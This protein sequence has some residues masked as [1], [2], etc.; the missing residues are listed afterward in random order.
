M[1]EQIATELRTFMDQTNDKFEKTNQL[2]Q[3]A[4]QSMNSNNHERPIPNSRRDS[5]SNHSE[6]EHSTESSALRPTMP[7][8]LTRE[9]PIMEEKP[10]TSSVEELAQMYA[11]LDLEVQRLISFKEYYEVRNQVNPN[12]RKRH[13]DKDLKARIRKMSLPYFDG[14]EKSTAQSWVQKLDTYLSLSPMIE[15]NAI[16]FATLFLA[17]IAQDWW[18]LSLITQGHQNITTYG[19][20]SQ[21]LSKRFNQRHLEWYFRELTLLTQQGSVEDYANEFQNFAVVVPDLSQG[22]LT[23]LFVEGHKESINKIVNPLERQRLGEA[24]QRAIKVE[25]KYSKEKPKY[26]SKAYPKNPRER[27]DVSVHLDTVPE[28]FH[29]HPSSPLALSDNAVANSQGFLQEMDASAGQFCEGER[30]LEKHKS[31]SSEVPMHRTLEVALQDKG[32]ER[33][34]QEANASGVHFC[35]GDESLPTQKSPSS[36]VPNTQFVSTQNKKLMSNVSSCSTTSLHCPLYNTGFVSVSPIGRVIISSPPIPPLLNKPLSFV[37][38]M[39]GNIPTEASSGQPVSSPIKMGSLE[40]IEVEKTPSFSIEEKAS[41]K[42]LKL[43]TPS[44]HIMTLDSPEKMNVSTSDDNLVNMIDSLEWIKASMPS[45]CQKKSTS[46]AGDGEPQTPPCI[47]KLWG[48]PEEVVLA[49]PDSCYSKSSYAF[50]ESIMPPVS[51][52]N[53]SYIDFSPYLTDLAER[54]IVP[55]SPI[56]AFSKDG[57][58]TRN[59]LQQAISDSVNENSNSPSFRI[60]ASSWKEPITYLHKKGIT[61]HTIA[62]GREV[63]KSPEDGKFA[64]PTYV[65][66]AIFMTGNMNILHDNAEQLNFECLKISKSS[67]MKGHSTPLV[68]CKSGSCSEDWN[69]SSADAKSVQKPQKFKRLCKYKEYSEAQIC[70]SPS[71]IPSERN[72]KLDITSGVLCGNLKHS[73][74]EKHS[75]ISVQSF[76]DEE[77]E[78]S[79]DEKVS[80]DEDDNNDS[81]DEVSESDSFIDDR[82]E[83][84]AALPT[85]AG[86]GQLDMMAVYR[87]SLFTQ[88]PAALHHQAHLCWSGVYSGKEISDHSKMT[89]ASA[90]TCSGPDV[91]SMENKSSPSPMQDAGIKNSCSSLL[92]FQNTA[93]ELTFDLDTC[94]NKEEYS[95][96]AKKRKFILQKVDPTE[97]LNEL[98]NQVSSTAVRNL[99]EDFTMSAKENTV[100]EPMGCTFDDD[101]FEGLDLD[102]LEA[103]AAEISRSRSNMNPGTGNSHLPNTDTL[104]VIYSMKLGSFLNE[105]TNIEGAKRTLLQV[106]DKHN[107]ITDEGNRNYGSSTK[108]LKERKLETE[109]DLNNEILCSPSFDLGI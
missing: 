75:K 96:I 100:R 43:T 27:A 14:S 59:S 18:H 87:R 10:A 56:L 25:A 73:K 61:D 67:A 109:N 86:S 98:D 105:V 93:D 23:Y 55:E 40:Q 49:T 108:F 71:K 91:I 5:H 104:D 72:D 12:R 46:D 9:E 51:T 15:E 78:V 38:F 45:S 106:S 21:K 70:V 22:R 97:K 52:A 83:F 32:S 58:V 90:D 33:I 77:A 37:P 11:G 85:Q 29:F 13:T 39:S 64:A 62:T 79:S 103:E 107:F 16:K 42:V 84:T 68:N 63:C 2:I 81:N 3:Q 88:S 24:I 95:N 94:S 60:V 19:E 66:P 80:T 28:H 65:S 54:G 30:S 57:H 44:N 41:W 82:L 101:I 7:P 17:G 1:A 34:F 48:V 47:S 53:A 74:G 31:T 20:F 36:E 50:K 76:I 4:I 69:L 102:A 35:Q 6:N 89:I 99:R 92:G 8:F 26:M